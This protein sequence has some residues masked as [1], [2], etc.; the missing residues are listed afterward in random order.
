MAAQPTKKGMTEDEK[1]EEANLSRLRQELADNKAA[2]QELQ[3]AIR[4]GQ[5][6]ALLCEGDASLFASCS[7]VLLALRQAWPDCPISV[8]PG[9]PSCSAAAAAGL[10]P[11]ALQQDQLLLRP[12]PAT[13]EELERVLERAPPLP[14]AVGGAAT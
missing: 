10:W 2:A 11:L 14:S 6:V 8:I 12:C 3:Q 7:Y 4:S 9:I 5:Q 13:P 1:L